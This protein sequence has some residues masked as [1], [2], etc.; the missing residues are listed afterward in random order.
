MKIE[1]NEKNLLIT[2]TGNDGGHITQQSVESSLLF[3]ILLKLEEIRCGGID[4]EAR[5]EELENKV[6]QIFPTLT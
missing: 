2:V 5:I 4:I 1:V 3:A 6:K